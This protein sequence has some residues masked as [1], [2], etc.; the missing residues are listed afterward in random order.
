MPRG[1]TWQNKASSDAAKVKEKPKCLN[2]S[3]A[4]HRLVT[5]DHGVMVGTC[6]ICH[7]V[8]SYDDTVYVA[9]WHDELHPINAISF[10]RS[11]RFEDE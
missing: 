8:Q 7:D 4:H 5:S 6:T 2:G 3:Y 9:N 10:E 1:L 11:S